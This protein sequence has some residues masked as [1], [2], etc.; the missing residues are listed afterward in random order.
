LGGGFFVGWE[1]QEN[2]IGFAER[3]LSNYLF[4]SE[5]IAVL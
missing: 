2:S 1:Y 4:V 3:I 5:L